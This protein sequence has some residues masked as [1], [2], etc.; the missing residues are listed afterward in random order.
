MWLALCSSFVA[1]VFCITH[2][3]CQKDLAANSNAVAT[4]ALTDT[5]AVTATTTAAA[6]ATGLQVWLYGMVMLW[7]YFSLI[8]VRARSSIVFFSRTAALSFLAFHVY[9]YHFQMGFFA[10]AAWTSFFVMFSVK[11]FVCLLYTSPSPRD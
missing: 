7:E 1:V 8:F 6:A 9:F 2:L 3:R 10:L 11:L 4:A 5:T